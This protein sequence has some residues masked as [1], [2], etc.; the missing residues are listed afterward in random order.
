MREK[1]GG[2]RF[3]LNQFLF[4]CLTDRRFGGEKEQE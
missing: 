1:A 4:F 3:F 2:G